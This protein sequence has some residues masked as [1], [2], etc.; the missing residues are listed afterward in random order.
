MKS[1]GK[2][3]GFLLALL[4][5]VSCGEK[6]ADTTNSSNTSDATTEA[7]AEATGTSTDGAT[8]GAAFKWE[9][10]NYDFGDMT[11]GEVVKHTYRFTN[12]GTAPLRI[13]SVKPSCGCTAP[14]WTREPVAP[15][16][17]GTIVVEFNSTGKT[18]KNNKKVTVLANTDPRATELTFQANVAPKG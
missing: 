4:F 7:G 5:L 10:T 8:A 3:A 16:A 9:E 18:G 13:E 11:E 6:A 14:D 12:T 15:G 17:T 1:I 2:M